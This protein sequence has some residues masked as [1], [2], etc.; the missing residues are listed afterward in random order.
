[1]FR[2]EPPNKLLQLAG[3][4]SAAYERP[5]KQLKLTTL[6][7]RRKIGDMIEVYRLMTGK[8][9]V[10]YQKSSRKPGVYITCE[11]TP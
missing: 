11:G 8:E 7:Q 3:M 2:E 10:E 9:N 4:E 6:E 5:L 1:M